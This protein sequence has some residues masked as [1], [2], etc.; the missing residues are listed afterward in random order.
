MTR[1][2]SA[3]AMSTAGDAALVARRGLYD[4]DPGRGPA[5]VRSQLVEAGFPTHRA[6]PGEGREL[7]FRQHHSR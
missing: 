5:P 2:R 7:V 6:G 4:I 3:P 1:I